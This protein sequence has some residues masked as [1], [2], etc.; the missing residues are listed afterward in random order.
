M[1]FSQLPVAVLAGAALLTACEGEAAGPALQLDATTTGNIAI[2]VQTDT[3]RTPTAVFINDAAGGT[4]LNLYRKG[5]T[6]LIASLTTP[7]S[8]AP[9]ASKGV[10]RFYGLVPGPYVI[11]SSLRPFSSATATASVSAQTGDSI[12]LT[13][14]AGATDTSGLLRVR[15]GAAVSGSLTVVWT[16]SIKVNTVRLGNTRLVFQRETA[17]GSTIYANID[18]TTTDATGAYA[19]AVPVTATPGPGSVTT[20]V[21]INF[22]TSTAGLTTPLPDAAQFYLG[23]F[24]TPQ[25]LNPVV[26]GPATMPQSGVGF[27]GP[28]T[29]QTF[30]QNLLYTF[31][32]QI[33]GRIYR[34]VNNNGLYD[35]TATGAADERLQPGDTVTVQLRN[36]DITA[37]GTRTLATSRL[38]PA[39]A[40]APTFTFSSIRQGNYR[41][42]ID[43]T[44]SRLAGARPLTSPQALFALPTSSFRFVTVGLPGNGIDVGVAVP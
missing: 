1:R 28:T 16:D 29:N 4:R 25:T 10:V 41:I 17:P 14:A 21:R 35:S 12:A 32:S 40:Q 23:G 38:T 24:A 42:W 34:A 33:Q 39:T 8:T 26:N 31:P 15:L 36:G 11:R 43:L 7:G 27:A 44:A 18:S 19:L 22:T 37:A 5:D 6:T 9:A 13:I 20:K 2:R 30:T 3:S